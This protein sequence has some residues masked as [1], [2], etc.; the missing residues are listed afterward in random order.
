M[1]HFPFIDDRVHRLPVTELRRLGK[2]GLKTL[3][4]DNLYVVEKHNEPVAVLLSFE[5][6]IHLQELLR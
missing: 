6:F 5:T 2:E 1:K 3:L 4:P